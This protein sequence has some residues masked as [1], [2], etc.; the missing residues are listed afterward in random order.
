MAYIKKRI[1]K[2]GRTSYQARVRV[3]GQK[4]RF[5]TFDRLSDAKTWAADT[6]AR[7]KLRSKLPAAEAKEHTLA[8]AIGRY[9]EEQ[10]PRKAPRTIPTQ[11]VHLNWWQD[12]M[13]FL[14]LDLVTPAEIIACRDHLLKQGF[15]STT[16]NHYL[17]SLSGV[18]SAA[19]RDWQWIGFNP[20]RTIRPLKEP[21]GRLRYLSENEIKQLLDAARADAYTLLYP[22]LILALTTGMRRAEL[23]TLKWSDIDFKRRM[24]SLEQTKNQERR[25]VPLLPAARDILLALKEELAAQAVQDFSQLVFRAPAT[26]GSAYW[27]IQKPFNRIISELGFRDF[28]WHD[29][30]HTCA[31]YLA[32]KG[33]PMRTIAEIL[34]HKTLQMV[35]RY[36]HL[37]DDHLKEAMISLDFIQ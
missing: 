16:A 33:I 27:A 20:C 1:S 19:E 31:S 8:E 13:G 30:R 26:G 9:L 32:M 6:E 21:Q 14:T 12:K 4:T 17:T 28:R 5:G 34:G 10:M 2:S 25:S 36:A 18:L 23:F 24:I 35:K 7:L 37:S 3:K 15:I 22:A 11:T 29:L